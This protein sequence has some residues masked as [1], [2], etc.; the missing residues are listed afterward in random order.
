MSA[1]DPNTLT[2]RSHRELDDVL[3]LCLTGSRLDVLLLLMIRP[4]TCKDITASLNIEA[5]HLSHLLHALKEH[6]LIVGRQVGRERAYRATDR[7]S[8][9]YEG[10]APLVRIRLEGGMLVTIQLPA[11]VRSEA[12]GHRSASASRRAP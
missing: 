11:P 6:E 10:P 4:H 3:A 9:G 1:E 12:N 8:L 2:P 7:V 5:S